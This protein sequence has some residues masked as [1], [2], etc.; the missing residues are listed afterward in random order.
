MDRLGD[1]KV[2][3]R[4]AESCSMFWGL[5][6]AYDFQALSSNKTRVTCL[7]KIEPK[8]FSLLCAR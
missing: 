5:E 2:Q 4:Y 1:E 8:V 7:L 6:G 3:H